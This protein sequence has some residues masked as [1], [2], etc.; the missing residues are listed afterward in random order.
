MRG[1]VLA[2]RGS[3]ASQATRPSVRAG[4]GRGARARPRGAGR[5]I[6]LLEACARWAA[7]GALSTAAC[8]ANTPDVPEELLVP[9]AGSSQRGGREVGEVVLDASFD[10]WMDPQ[11]KAPTDPME[12]IALHDFADPD[13]SGGA[14]VLL[15]NFS[16]A[17]CSP[18]IFEHR[19]LPAYYANARPR[20]LRVL[21][22]LFEDVDE[23]PATAE[24]VALWAEEYGTN[25]PLGMDP[26][27]VGPNELFSGLGSAPL[28]LIVD[29]RTLRIVAKLQGGGDV[30]AALDAEL[31]KP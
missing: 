29:A 26:E 14:R 28:N 17:W 20:G 25:F 23:S 31:A 16:A 15:V 7:L 6:A 22:L 11:G 27:H 4:S 9:G 8:G 12:R 24:L 13:E 2:A 3:H 18:C 21:S 19:Q 5:W 10:G 30:F 1:P